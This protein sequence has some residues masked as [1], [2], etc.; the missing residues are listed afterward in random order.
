MSTMDGA[1]P[2]RAMF[3]TK[4]AQNSRAKAAITRTGTSGG[5]F[6]FHRQHRSTRALSM[7]DKN[8]VILFR[9]YRYTLEPV[10]YS[11]CF[12]RVIAT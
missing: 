1:D 8:G 9:K 4:D 3:A 11:S 10:T 6:A 12:G 5:R 7:C 2:R